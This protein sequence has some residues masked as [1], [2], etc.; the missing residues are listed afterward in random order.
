MGLDL[1]RLL[2]IRLFQAFDVDG[3]GR[4]L[5]GSD[6]T[7]STQLIEIAGDDTTTQLTALPGTC[8][9]RYVPGQRAVIVSHDVG[10]NERYQLSLLRLPRENAAA[11]AD[12]EPLVRDPRYI[13]T[14]ADV[15]PG[16][17]CYLTNR[18]NGVAFDPVIRDLADGTER[19]INLGDHRFEEA[20]ISPDRRWLALTVASPVTA[21]ADHVALVDLTVPLDSEQLMLVTPPD[22]PAMNRALAWTP[23]SDALIFSSS[24]DRE[25]IAV[26]RHDLAKKDLTGW[27]P[28]TPPT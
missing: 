7:G 28:T 3:S 12:L 27:S 14:L 6:D 20:V 5:A 1:N 15:A 21:A 9:G 24:N 19:T 2:E 25:F 8:T 23:V 4:V 16:R 17:I 26:A 18:R 11:E 22:A 13:H 10:G